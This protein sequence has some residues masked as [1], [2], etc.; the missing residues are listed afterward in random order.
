MQQTPPL[1][2]QAI[3]ETMTGFQRS[4][5][6]KAAVELDVFT[7]VGADGATADELAAACACAPRGIRI[8][9]DALTVMGFLAKRENRYSLTDQSAAFLDRRSP[10][11]IGSA[12]EF[13]MSPVQ[14]RGFE[15]LANA[16]RQGGSTVTDHG[17]LE[18]ESPMW[19][20]F[21]HSMVGLMI[22]S[23]EM[24]ADRLGF[25]RERPLRVL[26]LAAGHGI[27]GITIARRYPHA[28]I[29]PLDW[30]NV[31][32][33]AVENAAKFGVGDRCHPIAGSAFEV[34]FG[35][36][37]DVVLATN[38]LHHFD[39]PTNETL[40]R[41]IHR[42]L[43]PDGR[44]MTLEFIP[45]EDRVSPAP[46][47]LFGLVMLAATPAG[48]AYTLAEL[49]QMLEAAGFKQNEYFPLDPTPQQLVV[50]TKQ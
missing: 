44:L 12:V 20:S 42:A 25:D 30:A 31:L 18:P 48:D 22:P 9:C 11:F 5:A 10:M 26:D 4:E 28:E 27:F 2:P 35:G 13:M 46:A 50:S 33:A 41:K 3:W 1:S 29:Y 6:F 16:V 21:A 17:S 37:Y 47:A 38:F 45:N 23:A 40:L 49:K 32:P 36:D 8:L 34:D 43:K 7:N 14:K 15:D 19:E 39:P 24:I